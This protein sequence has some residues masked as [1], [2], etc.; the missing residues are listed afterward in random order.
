MPLLLREDLCNRLDSQSDGFFSTLSAHIF[1]YHLQLSSFS[2]AKRPFKLREYSH[3]C[4]EPLPTIFLVCFP[5]FCF[6]LVMV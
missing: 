2:H 1:D 5:L 4:L 6:L 3:T